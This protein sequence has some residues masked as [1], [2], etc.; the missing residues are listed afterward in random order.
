MRELVGEMTGRG[1]SVAIVVS[2]FNETITRNLLLGAVDTLR[3]HGVPSDDITVAWVPGA[4]ELPLM[5]KTLAKTGQYDAVLCLGCIIRGATAHFDH[6]AG[7]CASNIAQLSLEMEIPVI[8]GVL[9][10]ENIEQAMERSGCKAGNKGADTA[11][12][13]VEMAQ[14]LKLVKNE[15]GSLV[16]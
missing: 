14:L 10:T 5:A 12:A 1:L 9:T 16:S 3:R 6:V 15:T 13:A 11:L 8:L 7:P 4:F 2:R